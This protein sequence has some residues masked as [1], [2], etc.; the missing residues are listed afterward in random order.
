MHDYYQKD[1]DLKQVKHLRALSQVSSRQ[2]VSSPALT[3][4]KSGIMMLS[5]I[6]AIDNM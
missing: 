5:P 3:I 6:V 2:M 4:V 1:Q